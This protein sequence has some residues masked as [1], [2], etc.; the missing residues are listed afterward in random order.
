MYKR[1]RQYN[2]ENVYMAGQWVFYQGSALEEPDREPSL[3]VFWSCDSW[4]QSDGVGAG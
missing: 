1:I 2:P 4:D 3:G